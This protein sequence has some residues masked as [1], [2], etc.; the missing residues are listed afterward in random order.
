[1]VKIYQI[2]KTREDNSRISISFVNLGL[3][4]RTWRMI[5]K[6][7]NKLEELNK[8]EEK[9]KGWAISDIKRIN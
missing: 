8:K 3:F 5:R 9:G 4:G 1:M 6:E 7:I 2:T